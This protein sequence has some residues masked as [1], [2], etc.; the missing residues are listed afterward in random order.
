MTSIELMI[1]TLV[2]ITVV[3]FVIYFII[4]FYDLY[5][6]YKLYL[7]LERKK[8]KR[9]RYLTTIKGRIP[10]FS[11]PFKAIPYIFNDLDT[12]DKNIK[13]YKEKLRSGL[14]LILIFSVIIVL[15]F[16]SIFL[17]AYFGGL[18]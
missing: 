3:I 13:K 14:K 15:L 6:I 9:W 7:Y 5:Y 10:L 2:A 18:I 16:A 8:F 1:I 12:G 17:T 4:G 11:N